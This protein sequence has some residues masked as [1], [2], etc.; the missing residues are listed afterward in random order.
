VHDLKDL[1]QFEVPT[2]AVERPPTGIAAVIAIALRWR[3]A[4]AKATPSAEAVAP[5][6]LE[7]LKYCR[8][9]FNTTLCMQQSP[10]F[11]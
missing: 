2:P 5:L 4:A 8:N 6:T 1:L 9:L 7:G 10:S 3:A 11:L